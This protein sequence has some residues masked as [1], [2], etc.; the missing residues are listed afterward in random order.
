MTDKLRQH[1]LIFRS[2]AFHRRAHV[3]VV[4]GCTLATA[5]L[6]GALLAGDSVRGS[7]RRIA[8][9]RLG[10]AELALVAEEGVFRAELADD[11][12]DELGADAAPALVLHGFAAADSGRR[13]AKVQVVGVDDRFRMISPVADDAPVPLSGEVVINERLAEMLQVD[14]GDELVLRVAGI[15]L[16]PREFALS[17]DSAPVDALRLTVKTVASM[18]QFGRFSLNAQQSSPM[19]AFVSLSDLASGL[20]HK[21]GANMILVTGDGLSADRADEVLGQ[22]WQLADAGLELRAVPGGGAELRSPRVFLAPPVADA[23]MSAMDGAQRVTTYFVNTI[24]SGQGATPYSFVSAPGTSVVPANMADD[25]ILLN[26]WTADDLGAAVGDVIDLAYYVL[27]PLRGL[28]ERTN[29][30]RVRAVVPITGAAADR[31]LMPLM[32][33]LADATSCSDWDPGIAIDLDRIRDKDE[34]YWDKHRGT[35]KAFITT[36]MADRMWSNRLGIVTAVRYPMIRAEAQMRTLASKLL[37]ELNPSDMRLGF[38][39]VKSE[40]QAAVEGGVDF[41]QLFLGLSFFLIVAALVLTG[42]LFV[43]G[44]ETRVGEARMLLAVGWPV[45][46]VRRLFLVEGLAL[47]AVG[48]LCG[49]VVGLLYNHAVLWGLGTVW[50]GAVGT[51][52]LGVHVQP[53]T[54]GIGLVSG[55]AAAWL[56]MRVAL[57]TRVFR[58]A[59]LRHY[60]GP[61]CADPRRRHAAYGGIIAAA[62][63]VLALGAILFM[64]RGSGAAVAGVFMMSG[65]LLLLGLLAAVYSLLVRVALSSQQD[66]VPS[67]ARTTLRSCARRPGRSLSVVGML[68]CGVFMV[69]AV[70][71]NH[72]NPMANSDSRSSGT[73]GFALVAETAVPITHDL[74][75]AGGRAKLGLDALPAEVS[76][77]Q[78][79]VLDGDDASCLNLN[80]VSNPPILGV[81]VRELERRGS[82]SFAGA[83]GREESPWSVLESASGGIPAVADQSVLTWGLGKSVGDSLQYVDGSGKPVGV[84]LA[85]GLANS[86]FQGNLLISEQR[87]T[88]LFPSKSGTRMLLV[89]VPP[90]LE[91]EVAAVLRESMKDFGI[92]VVGAPERLAS[93]AVVEQTYL[94]IFFALGGLGVALGTIGMGAAIMRNVLERR[95]ELAALQALGYSKRL[96][97]RLLAVEHLWLFMSGL[98]VGA[99]SGLLAVGPSLAASGLSAA[100]L[101]VLILVAVV[102]AS[103]VAW[104]EIAARRSMP[105]D[106][107]AALR[108]E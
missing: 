57:R 68:A 34:E 79:R 91:E 27:G 75:T 24:A 78:V 45:A 36:V 101:P 46:M 60:M 100:L 96:L 55:I 26:K 38:R 103:G 90:G 25:E 20:G 11:V 30:F 6:V 73:G 49:V 67:F 105:K 40:A 61:A 15:D 87:F 17:P 106:L 94:M 8:L 3:G 85:A 22:V 1:N 42:L 47:A 83:A 98:G 77:V 19:T 95:S 56:S 18:D 71:A 80:R 43:F 2:L 58:A 29:H 21:G 76:F 97:Q 44:V 53:G 9:A 99:A 59:G 82:F 62:S 64:G 33:G 51:S 69:I 37:A 23:A 84:T 4:L 39:A 93:F 66:C 81:P 14:E 32:P 35:P 10:R 107:V 70:G 72:H 92:E 7:L 16:L 50:Q 12:A 48:G 74:N 104:I 108:N 28:E 88:K 31:E 65:T 52:D 5:V 63:L 54:V 86:I 13:A 102:F 41:G 89:D